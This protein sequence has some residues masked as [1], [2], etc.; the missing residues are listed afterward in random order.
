MANSYISLNTQAQKDHP[1]IRTFDTDLTNAL[2]QEI[3]ALSVVDFNSKMAEAFRQI[4]N[5]TGDVVKLK[6]KALFKFGQNDSVGSTDTTVMAF[7]DNEV[8]EAYVFD[9]LIDSLSTDDANN[10]QEFVIEGHTVSGSGV[11][12]QYTFVTQTCT[13][14]GTATIALDTPLAR[15]TR[16]YNNSGTELATNSTVYV[17]QNVSAPGG[18]PSDD[19][20]VHV[21]LQETG[22]NSSL[23]AATCFSNVDYWI[24]QSVVASVN[25]KTGASAD[26]KIQI[27]RPGKVFRTAFKFSVTTDG[28]STVVIPLEQYVIVPKNSDVRMVANASTTNVS[29]SGFMAGPIAT[30][31]T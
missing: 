31:V 10:N 14:S 11:N 24:I 27:R 16:V 30:V 18:I 23:K 21:L 28:S 20:K 8:H 9:N 15:A 3:H 12:A 4:E 7:M 5:D 2:G 26:I 29:I 25:K 19:T 1:V 17:F 6:S 13:A 22:D